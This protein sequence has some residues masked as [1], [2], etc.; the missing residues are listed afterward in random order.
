MASF[1]DSIPKFNPYVSQ[2]PV[3]LMAKVGM[4]KQQQYEQGIQKIQ[5]TIDSVAGLDV[6]KDEDKTYLQSKLNELG[7]DLKWVGAS[8][9]SDFQLV[10]SVNGMTKQ[11][12]KDPNILNA[13]SS[14]AFVKK[15]L[16]FMEEERKKGKLN[17][18]NEYV[19]KQ[20]LNDWASDGKVGSTFSYKYDPYFDV[21][22]F[23]KETFD[24][25]L[26]DS[27]TYEEVFQLDGNGKPMRD[28]KGN[29]ILNPTMTR[30][31]K[32][33]RFPEKV[34]QTLNQIMS[35]PRVA[36]QL[37]IDGIYNY[38]GLDEIALSEKI[39]SQKIEML[40][41]YENKLAE[42]ILQKNTGK[43]VQSEIDNLYSKIETTVSAYD[44]Y[45]KTASENPDAIRAALYKDD[46][47]SRYT[48]MFG[49]IKESK[50]TH[51]NPAWNQNWKM[52]VEANAQSRWA[53][54]MRQ[55]KNEFKEELQYKYDAL[56]SA[57]EVARI[58]AKAKGKQ[59]LGDGDN[60][61][62][63]G[64]GG[65]P[66]E[67]AAQSA[68]IEVIRVQN[69]DY[70][71]AVNDYSIKSNAF[72]WENIFGKMPVNDAK[73]KDLMSKGV[74][75]EAAIE[76][77]INNAARKANVSP[78][79]FKATWSTRAVTAFKKLSPEEQS[80]RPIMEKTYKD[81]KDSK[82]IFD[83]Q[84]LIK[85]RIDKKRQQD[86]G[87]VGKKIAM[88]DIKPQTIT[89][90]DKTY[91]LTKEDMLDIAIY[92]K[93]NIGL[94]GSLFSGEDGRALQQDSKMALSRLAKR[95]KAELAEAYI[96]DESLNKNEGFYN[97][98]KNVMNIPDRIRYQSEGWG[99]VNRNWSQVKQVEEIMNNQ[100]YVEGL[101]KTAEIIKEHYN[102]APNRNIDII[103]GDG[104]TDKN[105]I[106]K[107]RRWGSEAISQNANLS[108]DFKKFVESIKTDP[109]DNI[110]GATTIFDE[111]NNPMVEI[112]SYNEAGKRVGG[113]TIQ[114]D[115][116]RKINIDLGTLYESDEASALRNKLNY[117]N[118][119][120]S[121]GDPS[122][123]ATYV[124]GDSWYDKYDFPGMKGNKN[125]DVQANIVYSSGQYFPY[126][127]IKD[128]NKKPVVR[129]L[130]GDD[131]LEN[132]LITLKNSINPTLVKSL[133]IT[134]N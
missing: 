30:I 111:N 10:N 112:V 23:V 105:T 126:L 122:D 16:S 8:D 64:P 69:A 128:G 75:K 14:T 83:S 31:E 18:S 81:Y 134:P 79:E 102:I 3:E 47:T 58:N 67:Q 68:A 11:I 33:G 88:L 44:E 45:I 125:F 133:L 131:N 92:K 74:K 82:R 38:R 63:Y 99:G 1:T 22:K 90:K 26:P 115:Q 107:L 73:L 132:I 54:E 21:N 17:P 37:S 106:A 7:N 113:L 2:L 76:L 32:E 94:M 89:Y 121:V 95:G 120:T 52:Q 42:L 29:F 57:E 124:N 130:P 59:K 118:Y 71:K 100:T 56:R 50:T 19:F 93:G 108:S 117:N 72:I 48:T 103:T 60:G 101:K 97:I 34:R 9:F 84:M 13:V 91:T 104:E 53:Q 109:N 116:A 61:E 110:L 96:N 6:Y 119:K 15:E 123:T 40:S 4:A 20:K 43:D 46:V 98:V 51:E 114:P 66:S 87:E 78:E 65:E 127:Y 77:L 27:F 62:G 12:A 70:E 129:E 55:R 49:Q 35:D 85:E 80:A 41:Q 25:V 24:S 86:L 28:S 5:S 36:K 39:S